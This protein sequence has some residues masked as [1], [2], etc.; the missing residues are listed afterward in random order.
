M[1]SFVSRPLAAAAAL[2][3]AGAL[4]Q[5]PAEGD[6]VTLQPVL[7][8]GQRNPDQSTLTQPDLPTARR[9]IE[10]TPGGAGL[11]DAAD[12][13]ERRVATLADALGLATG[14]FVQPRFGA[15]EARLAIRGSGLQ[16]TF[17]GRGLKLMQDGVPLNLADGSY[18]FQAVEA[19][20][21]R[22]VE[23]W[24]GANA[25]QYGASQLGGA[26]NFVSPNGYNADALRLRGEAGSFG[27]RRAHASTGLVD[28][29]FDAYLA[30]SHFGQDGFRDHAEQ[31]SQRAFANLGWQLASDLETRFYLGAVRSRSELPGSL[32]RQQLDDD[33]RQANPVNVTGD[34]KRDIDWLRLSNKT[35]WRLAPQQQLE[36]FVYLAAKELDHPIFQVLRQDS[37]DVGAE[38]RWVDETP[39]AG[40]R[41]RLVAGLSG[42]RGVTDDDRYVNVGGEAGARTDRNRQTAT[43]V[44][45]YGEWQH[46]WRPGWW[47]VLGAQATRATRRFEDRYVVAGNDQSF[48]EHYRRLSPKLGLR[49]EVTPQ[50]QWFANLSGS[51]EPP[52]FGELAGGATPLL[53]EA[54]RGTTLE[55]GTRG[56]VDGLEWDAALYATRLRKELL[57][58]AGTAG[59]GT[60]VNADRTWHRGLELGLAG[61]APR[62]AGFAWRLA[63]LL[64]DFRFDDD[65]SYGDGRLAGLPRASLRAEAGWR[66]GEALRVV[67]NT[68]AATRSAVDHAQTLYAP[69]YALLGLRFEGRA[70]AAGWF[71]EGRNL[72]DRRYAASHGVIRDARATGA[73]LAQFLP[74]EGRAVY[75]GIDW[76]L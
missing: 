51:F 37:R 41:N 17:H 64:N 22:Y 25:L 50:W 67:L 8:S 62:A 36:G 21:A 35:V 68:E 2:A 56:R 4:A 66:F 30:V 73:T 69:G 11:V 72:G 9:R 28:G 1:S 75:A 7:V 42:A 63:A 16:R 59:N 53:N 40:R 24:R 34:Q 6:A 5:S 32:T 46:E 38:L 47:G 15:E 31:G 33:P 60:T 39:R 57:A 26:V 43:N 19:L 70:G 29:A 13:A 23:V 55:L 49:H 65:A 45:L 71:V 61:G 10:L 14:V 76:K 54:Q 48:E 20:S 52:S 44:E 12:Y 3:C 27:Y 74:G 58:L 18:D